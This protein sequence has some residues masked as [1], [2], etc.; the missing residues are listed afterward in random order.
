M[1][2]VDEPLPEP[3]R[4]GRD[5]LQTALLGWFAR[6]G[7]DLPW[8]RGP[9]PYRTW[10]SEVML[11][12]TQV[13]RVVGYFHRFMERFPTVDRLAE[14]PEA[15]V[16]R[17]WEGL[18]YYRRARQLHAAAKRIV[19]DH[20]GLLPDSV[21]ALRGLPGIG[22][23]TAGAIASIA[24]DRPEP[25]VEANSRR[26]LARLTAHA[27]PLDGTAGDGPIW[28]IA[29]ALVPARRAGLWN[30]A[31]MDLGATV[32]TPRNPICSTCPLA[33]HCLALKTGQAGSIPVSTAR[34]KVIDLDETAVV[35]RRG[36]KVL[37]VRRG[38]G[39]WWEGLWDFPRLLAKEILAPL[40][41][42]RRRV[43]GNCSYTV[44]HHRV[45][46]TVT[47]CLASRQGPRRDGVAWIDWESLG[48]L[49]MTAP[50]RRI[51]ALAERGEGEAGHGSA[52]SS[53]PRRG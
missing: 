47:T 17:A 35:V 9:D 44:T 52:R 43:V 6:V 26:V 34:R 22:R 13:E 19:A 51:A 1:G 48:T 39:E 18:G 37:V 41:C 2:T 23:Y 4:A 24:F 38:A 5:S 30:Q 29:S 15:D 53:R 40:G 10:I 8:R 49:A 14:A 11:Q 16:L 27:S 21:A 25:V 33:P 20:G 32:C 28:M 36:V 7:R 50:G 45:A 42:G 3:L 46:V 12:Q 31:L